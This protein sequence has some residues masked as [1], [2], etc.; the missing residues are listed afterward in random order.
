MGLV[1]FRGNPHRRTNAVANPGI[2]EYGLSAR[3]PVDMLHDCPGN[4]GNHPREILM[5]VGSGSPMGEL[6]RVSAFRATLKSRERM[7]DISEIV[8]T[9]WARD[10]EHATR[11]AY[12]WSDIHAPTMTV[13]EVC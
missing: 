9:V 12:E 13:F 10:T 11:I 3:I 4:L 7:P 2:L 5:V 6:R 8:L 1:P